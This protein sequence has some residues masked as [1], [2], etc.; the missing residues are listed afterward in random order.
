MNTIAKQIQMTP[1]ASYTVE[2]LIAKVQELITEKPVPV[3][4][5]ADYLGIHEKSLLRQIHN[6]K[7]PA[8]LT[9][10]INTRHYF[11]LSEIKNYIQSL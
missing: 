3:K 2:D 11:F 8:K 1:P 10:K 5:A 7:F 6:G 9:H 4:V